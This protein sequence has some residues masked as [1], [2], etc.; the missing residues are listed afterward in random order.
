M[1]K[2]LYIAALGILGIILLVGIGYSIQD[3]VERD[4]EPDAPS[5]SIEEPS[6]DSEPLPAN[7]G[8]QEESV[9]SQETNPAES[10][11]DDIVIEEGESVEVTGTILSRYTHADGHIFTNVELDKKNKSIDIPFFASFGMEDSELLPGA[12]VEVH[13]TVE[14]YQGD[15]QIVPSSRSGIEVLEEG[16]PIDVKKK[17]L[18]E[19]TSEDIGK[20]FQVQGTV[21]EM[22]QHDGHTF[23]NFRSEGSIISAA[24]FRA[25]STENRGR[26]TLISR[27]NREE[28]EIII[29]ASVD[30]YRDDLQLVVQKVIPL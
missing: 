12:N 30:E 24:L 14:R 8:T 16:D 6:Q 21:T 3:N 10:Q 11:S 2:P 13:G 15:L 23:F 17:A 26:Q 5:E 18:A 29:E 9:T 4:A 22:R 28:T 1:K 25:E 27:S 20:V 7:E 19:I